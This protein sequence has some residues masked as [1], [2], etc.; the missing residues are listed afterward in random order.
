MSPTPSITC[1][2]CGAVHE[3]A[4]RAAAATC[5]ACGASMTATGKPVAKPTAKPVAKPAAK[6][7]AKPATPRDVPTTTEER[8]TPVELDEGD[9]NDPP[10]EV[11]RA[12]TRV[13]A[14]PRP[15]FSPKKKPPVG[16]I[17]GGVALVVGVVVAIVVFSKGGDSNGGPP[18]NDGADRSSAKPADA[19]TSKTPVVDAPKNDAA[20]A[21][22]KPA[23]TPAPVPESGRDAT[24]A[25]TPSPTPTDAT[26]KT[27]APAPQDGERVRYDDALVPYLTAPYVPAFKREDIEKDHQYLLTAAASTG[28]LVRKVDFDER[29]KPIIEK[30]GDLKKQ[31]DAILESPFGVSSKNL[32]EATI[33]D[34]GDIFSGEGRFVWFIHPDF[35][36]YVVVIEESPAWSTTLVVEK[37]VFRPLNELHNLFLDQY[38]VSNNLTRLTDPVPVVFFE[39]KANYEKYLDARGIADKNILAHFEPGSGRLVLHRDCTHR[40]VMHE[41]T[42]QLFSRYS[43][44]KVMHSRQSYWFEEGVAE[45]FGGANRVPAGDGTWK[46]EIGVING[47]R[48]N[49]MRADE[50][51]TW[52]SVR[53]L[54]KL[55]YADRDR[56]KQEGGEGSAK[57]LRVYAQGWFLI[58]FLNYFDVDAQGYVKFGVRGKYADGWDAYVRGELNGKTGHKAF[59]DA[60]GLDTEEKWTKIEEEY[61]NYFR[62]V[63]F[64]FNFK[65]VKDDRL[66]PYD[67]YVNKRGEK[68]GYKEQDLLIPPP[69][70]TD[71]DE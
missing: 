15:D 5:D 57:S 40:T 17:L 43:K 31:Y 24:G 16:L 35:Q 25:P 6:P 53:E 38:R 67:Q 3:A 7:V 54:T 12:H 44:N 34:L 36:P 2:S 33:K 27:S 18:S 52:F 4:G 66:V 69:K 13:M 58:Y 48:I 37:D 41:G 47:G 49:S 8:V 23:P 50:E 26:A 55:T 22:D 56:W 19:E 60:L 71:D 51:K 61:K 46:Y 39:A 11:R 42:H 10:R 28:G 68:T 29:V 45:W 64:K 62:F 30:Y 21:T 63:N 59:C 70:K 65:H 20:R 32:A 14:A 9:A 1:P